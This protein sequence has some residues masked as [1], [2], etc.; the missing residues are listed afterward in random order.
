MRLLTDIE[1]KNPQNF[2]SPIFFSSCM[3][4]GDRKVPIPN[5][6]LA[7]APHSFLYCSPVL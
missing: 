6:T 2:S 3:Y 5:L 7:H 1:V 4:E